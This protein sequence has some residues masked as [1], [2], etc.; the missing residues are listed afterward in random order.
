MVIKKFALRIVQN[1]WFFPFAL[2]LIGVVAYGFIIP[3]LGF[4][5]DDWEGVYLYYLHN[6]AGSFAYFPARPLSAIADLLVFSLVKMT[7]VAM[8]ISTLLIRWLATLFIYFTLNMLLPFQKGLN[9]WVAVLLF[10]FP[11]F[12]EQPVSVAFTQHFVTYLF[13]ASSIFL[14]VLALKQRKLFWLW[15][16]L[17][18]L[19]GGLQMFMMEYFVGLEI[20]R[21]FLIW[22]VLRSEKR[23]GDR[24][25]FWKTLAYWSPFVVVL[26]GYLYWRLAYLPAFLAGDPNPP[27]LLKMLL[28]SPLTTLPRLLVMAYQDFLHLLVNIWPLAFLDVTKMDITTKRVW[29]TWVIGALAATAFLFYNRSVKQGTETGSSSDY[30][31]ALVGV[32]AHALRGCAGLGA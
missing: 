31:S 14:L 17:S 6:P 2:L 28:S 21:P 8:Q 27:I 30:L 3:S 19:F 26:I 15:M 12:L 13:F 32:R 24:R 7:P 29:L 20:I 9:R 5:W 4:Y 23:A 22:F 1:P 18:I 10:V 16:P 25:I 11:G